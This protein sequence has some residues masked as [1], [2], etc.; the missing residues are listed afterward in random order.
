MKEN[1]SIYEFELTSDEIQEINKLHD[2]DDHGFNI[3]M[4]SE[5]W[6]KE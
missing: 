3:I 5:Q 2:S 1:L 4:K 6:D